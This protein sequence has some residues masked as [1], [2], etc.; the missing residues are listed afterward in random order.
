MTPRDGFPRFSARSAWRGD[1][2]ASQAMWDAVRKPWEAAVPV[3]HANRRRASENLDDA[4]HRR[5]LPCYPPDG[6]TDRL[7]DL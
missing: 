2:G 3:G 5:R 6:P 7:P 1:A 4:V